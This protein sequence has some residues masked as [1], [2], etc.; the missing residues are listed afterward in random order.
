MKILNITKGV[1]LAFLTGLGTIGNTSIFVNYVLMFGGSEKKSLQIILIHLTFTNII[2]LLS[3]GMP[4]TIAAF[5]LRNFLSNIGCK[6]VSFL[7]RVARG[8]SICTSSLLTVVQVMTISPTHSKWKRIK[9]RTEWHFLSLLILFWM[10]NSLIGMNLLLYVTNTSMNTS[11]INESKSYC[12]FQPDNQNMKLIFL[13]LMVIRDVVFQSVMG[14][15]SGYMVFLLHKHHQRVL[16][17]QNYKVLYKTPPEIKAAQSVLFLMICFLF[18]YWAD[19]I[20]SLCI[21]CFLENNS[22][23]LNIREILTLGYAFLSPFV[24]IH[25][26]KHLSMCWRGQWTEKH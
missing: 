12:Y 25:R 26:D 23:L 20:L 18:F 11:Y 13:T 10:L 14:G 22:V 6:T 19:C 9:P 8:L 5:G 15:A 4:S 16:H 3:S 2:T 1:I 24:L 17:L 7:E 21:I